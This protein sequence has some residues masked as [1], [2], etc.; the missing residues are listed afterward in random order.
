MV[1]VV[2]VGLCS[3][4]QIATIVCLIYLLDRPRGT[5]I[6]TIFV[7]VSTLFDAIHSAIGKAVLI[8]GRDDGL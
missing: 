7:S 8:R 5:H 3:L 4:H 2:L 1:I 6:K